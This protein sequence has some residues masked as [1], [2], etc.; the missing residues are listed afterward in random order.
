[1]F[2]ILYREEA[3]EFDVVEGVESNLSDPGS[4][5][6]KALAEEFATMYQNELLKGRAKFMKC[7]QCGKYF[8][9]GRAEEDWFKHEGLY[10]P[11]RC[12]DCRRKNK[13]KKK[14]STNAHQA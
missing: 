12:L 11:K 1:M 13:Q 3:E 2:A 10:C 4:G 6:D 9:I 5:N 7:K 14:A 8:M